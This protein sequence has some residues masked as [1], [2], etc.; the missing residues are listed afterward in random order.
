[1]ALAAGTRE[2]RL[3]AG[4]TGRGCSEPPVAKAPAQRNVVRSTKSCRPSTTNPPTAAVPLR[5]GPHSHPIT[6]IALAPAGRPAPPLG[7]APRAVQH[8]V[9]D[10]CIQVF[11]LQKK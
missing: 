9:R 2:Q 3:E 1:M 8:V 11:F 6:G 5:S 10:R 4:W 7:V